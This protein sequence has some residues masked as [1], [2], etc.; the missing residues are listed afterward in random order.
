MRSVWGVDCLLE[1]GESASKCKSK[2]KWLIAGSKRLSCVW[3]KRVKRVE[4]VI[5]GKK[6][7]KGKKR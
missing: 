3:V 6:E 4:K 2:A 7:G 5:K 1:D